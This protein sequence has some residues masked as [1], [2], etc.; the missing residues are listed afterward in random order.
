MRGH[1][2][3]EL[4]VVVALLG[5]VAA[6]T[7][8]RV[9]AALDGAKVRGAA[10]YVSSRFGLARTLAAHRNANVAFRFEQVDGGIQVRVF[11]DTNGNGIRAI[12]IARGIDAEIMPAERLDHAFPGVRYGFIPGA[13]LIDGTSVTEDDDPIRFG[14]TD[15]LIFSPAGTATAGTVYIR[16]RDHWQY[17]VVVLGATGRTRIARFDL[18]TR[19]WLAP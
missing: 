16:G 19:R 4:L 3:V 12:E 11:A 18:R 1:S 14:S 6:L 2:L 8:P 9:G 5:A 17:A 13:R 10:F 7:V 15:M